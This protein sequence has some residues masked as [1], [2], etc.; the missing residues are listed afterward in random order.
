[1][2]LEAG[3]KLKSIRVAPE[4]VPRGGN[5]G[6]APSQGAK[7]TSAISK[8]HKSKGASSVAVDM[9]SDASDVTAMP[10]ARVI[11]I[12]PVGTTSTYVLDGMIYAT[13]MA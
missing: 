1:V 3:M 13:L 10:D 8:S 6:E 7:L 11:R 9:Q 2:P 5:K 12:G 4:P